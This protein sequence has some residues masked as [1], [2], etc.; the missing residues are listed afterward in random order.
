MKTSRQVASQLEELLILE[1][2][3]QQSQP[4]NHDPAQEACKK[5]TVAS[6]AEAAQKQEACKT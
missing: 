3:L 6:N 1:P 5:A 2:G 4:S